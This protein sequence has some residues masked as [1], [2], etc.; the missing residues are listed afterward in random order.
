TQAESNGHLVEVLKGM[1]TVKAA[2]GEERALAHW[3]D[4]FINQ[5]NLSLER[6]RL[7]AVVEAA[8]A[9]LRT[10]TPL[11]LL[12][13]GALQVLAGTFSLGTMLALVA[14]ATAA[15][16]PLGSLVSAGQ[17]WQLVG[18]HLDRVADVVQAEPEQSLREVRPAPPLTGRIELRGVGFRYDP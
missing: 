5:L 12:W 3:S 4:L 7:A 15:L 17:Q 16:A 11:L 1:A 10:F 18:A 6:G 14:L 8:L 2:G 9:A 13:G